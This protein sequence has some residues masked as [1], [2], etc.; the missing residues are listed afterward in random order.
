MFQAKA[1]PDFAM[2]AETEIDLVFAADDT[3]AIPKS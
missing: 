3:L 2:P 1:A